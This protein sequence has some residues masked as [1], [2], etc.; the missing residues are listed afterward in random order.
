MVDE[1]C[2]YYII[3][4]GYKSIVCSNSSICKSKDKITKE[5]LYN[6]LIFGPSTSINNVKIM[7]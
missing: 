6:F 2:I 5:T 3:S 4:I 7:A 1:N